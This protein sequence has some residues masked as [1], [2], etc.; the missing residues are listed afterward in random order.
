[1]VEESNV[2]NL[3]ERIHE[4]LEEGR[5]DEAAGEAE[6]FVA[7]VPDSAEAHC[8]LGT[9]RAQK[10]DLEAALSSLERALALDPT[11]IPAK[12]EK[13]RVL[14][15]ETRFEDV[16]ETLSDEGVVEALYLS[17]S[18]LYELG[19]HEES[20]L[21][22]RRALDVE[23]LPELRHLEALLWLSRAEGEKA[24]AAAVRAIE[25]ESELAEGHHALGLAWTQLGEMEKADAAFKRAAELEPEA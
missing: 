1:M 4:L 5:I 7:R 23:E 8:L 14:Y 11:L 12:L 10:G 19:E 13:A 24:R 2:R 22:C 25:L 21:V 15:D 6:R 17:A 20:E 3:W 18:A 16:I 9:V